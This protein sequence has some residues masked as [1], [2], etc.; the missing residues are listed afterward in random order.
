MNLQIKLILLSITGVNLTQTYQINNRKGRTNEALHV[1][2]KEATKTHESQYGKAKAYI[3]N[4][5]NEIIKAN[6]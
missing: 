4:A 3:E 5:Y 1:Q 6:F 2:L